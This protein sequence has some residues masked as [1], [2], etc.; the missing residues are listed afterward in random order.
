VLV[1]IGFLTNFREE[2]LMKKPEYRQK[3]AEALYKGV[4]QY[5]DSLSHFR[6]AQSSSPRT[7]SAGD[8]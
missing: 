5:A 7:L 3:L 2:A 8:Q 1:E 4:S 6:V